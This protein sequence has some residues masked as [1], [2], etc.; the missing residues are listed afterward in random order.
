LRESIRGI[1]DGRMSETGTRQG[2]HAV[3]AVSNDGAFRVIVLRATETA[4]GVIAAQSARGKTAEHLAGLV[5]GTLLVRLTMAPGYRVQGIVR[6]SDEKTMLVA[7]SYPDGATR[8]L[9]KPADAVLT[10]GQGAL[11][12]MMRSLPNGT[13]HQGV[14]EVSREHGMSGA[15]MNYMLESEQVTSAIGVGVVTTDAGIAIAGGYVVQLL[16]ECTD[17]PLAIMYE[18]LRTDFADLPLV[19]STQGGDP[20]ALMS[21]IL[22]GMPYTQTQ[23]HELRYRCGCSSER[24]LASLA[25]IAKPDLEDMMRAAE[26]L[27]ITC[28]YCNTPYEVA[29]EALR[30]LVTAS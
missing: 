9:I 17:P 6:G 29:P 11:M 13:T 1:I 20:R 19:L 3:T 22:Y 26:P 16:P 30:G 28:D 24:V 8:G 21:E 7:D 10:L 18:R 14:V 23:E 25:T 5:T 2:D 15:L 27:F 12:Q 4:R